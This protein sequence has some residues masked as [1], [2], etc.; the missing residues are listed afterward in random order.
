MNNKAYTAIKRELPYLNPAL[1]RIG[2]YILDNPEE[3]KTITTKSLAAACG[4]AESTVTRFVKE[5]GFS[6]F[7]EL[8]ISLAEY[9]TSNETSKDD[10]VSSMLYEALSSL[11][12]MSEVVYKLAYRNICIL[13]DTMQTLRTDTLEKAIEY[14]ARA[15][16]IILC[17]QGYSS[18][19]SCEA[20]VMFA[21][22]GKKCVFYEDECSLLMAASACKPT[23]LF[24]SISNTGRTKIVTDTIALAKEHGGMTIG[25]TSFED[26]PLA[27]NSDI[28]IITPARSKAVESGITWEMASAKTAQLLVI[29]ILCACYSLEYYNEVVDK[30]DVTYQAIKNTRFSK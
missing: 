27:V 1:K 19:A 24:I 12:S 15:E 3:C 21:R 16:V 25:I 22:I 11:D 18:V 2:N 14:I 4:V 13:K 23:D 7:Q 29:D 9:L 8:K 10:G 6:G 30:M 5:I 20:K 28:A 17:S 26:S